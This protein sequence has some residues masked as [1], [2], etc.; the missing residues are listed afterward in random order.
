MCSN[1]G[2]YLN[3]IIIVSDTFHLKTE[4]LKQKVGNFYRLW[5]NE[6]ILKRHLCFSDYWNNEPNRIRNFPRNLTLER[7]KKEAR[8]KGNE[9]SRK[10]FHR[11]LTM[12]QTKLQDET[13][14]QIMMGQWR[15]RSHIDQDTGPLNLNLIS[16][17]WRLTG[18]SLGLFVS[19]PNVVTLNTPP[20]FV[21][22]Y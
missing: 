18:G 3:F 13:E 5:R 16:G 4:I 10:T 20:S 2:L 9:S 11:I 19:L 21:L 22:H 7:K 8:Q 14:A 15:L 1:L 17:H 12:Y 6:A